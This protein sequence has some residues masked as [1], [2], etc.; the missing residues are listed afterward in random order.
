MANTKATKAKVEKLIEG[1]GP[2]GFRKLLATEQNRMQIQFEAIANDPATMRFGAAIVIFAEGFVCVG[3]D[4]I[5]N[6]NF[7]VMLR[8]FNVREYGTAIGLYSLKDGPTSSTQLEACPDIFIPS[9][10]VVQI[11]PVSESAWAEKFESWQ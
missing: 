1:T 4:V 3:Q 6:P 9:Q 10:Q 11:L 2:D 7:C 8:T 5:M